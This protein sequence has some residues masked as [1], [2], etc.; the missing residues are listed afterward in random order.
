MK[1]PIDSIDWQL[2]HALQENAR[3]SFSELARRVS[4]TPPAVSA[5][6]RRLEEVGVLRGYHADVDPARAGYP[7][8]A[9]IRIAVPSGSHCTTLLASLAQ[10]PEVH[11]A[12]RVTGT[13]SAVVRA[14]VAT[15]DHLEDLIDRL[16]PLGKLTTSIATSSFRKHP[17]VERPSHTG[18]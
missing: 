8:T 12:Y 2:V 1:V 3:L 17:A 9:V 7:I 18:A 5:R 16:A 10:V 11:E 13:D 6:V 14:Q 15:S 4:L